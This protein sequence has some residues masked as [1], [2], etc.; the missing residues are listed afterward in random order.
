[1]WL[2]VHNIVRNDTSMRKVIVLLNGNM[3][4]SHCVT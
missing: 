2:Y 4:N 3:I 1:V